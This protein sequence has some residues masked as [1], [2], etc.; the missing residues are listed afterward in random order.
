MLQCRRGEG[1]SG[2][3][4][5]CVGSL[6]IDAQLFCRTSKFGH[7]DSGLAF[8]RVGSPPAGHLTLRQ[9]SVVI[10]ATVGVGFS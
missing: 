3:A 6:A 9:A 1:V 4:Q 10:Q 8:H 2:M 7:V 5:A